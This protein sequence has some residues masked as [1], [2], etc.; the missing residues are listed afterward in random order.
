ME[1]VNLIFN[2]TATR[3][4]TSPGISE[5]TFFEYTGGSTATKL[6]I[7]VSPVPAVRFS[8]NGGD[9]YETITVTATVKNAVSAWYMPSVP[10]QK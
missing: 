9:F 8:P 1:S 2:K 4:T 6:D 5:D 7:S 10:A 3:P